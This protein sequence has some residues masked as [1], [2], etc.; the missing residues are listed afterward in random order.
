MTPISTN[1][2]RRPSY[3]SQGTTGSTGS[4]KSIPQKVM[5]L[6]VSDDTSAD[7]DSPSTG[8]KKHH[9]IKLP[10]PSKSM[11]FFNKKHDDDERTPSPSMAGEG[12]QLRAARSFSKPDQGNFHKAA[13][14]AQFDDSSSVHSGKG[15]HGITRAHSHN[16]LGSEDEEDTLAALAHKAK[17]S[18]KNIIGKLI[19]E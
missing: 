16:H 5:D 8:S 15:K 13:T 12:H 9:K 2:D 4:K 10:R 11:F 1:V 7:S 19:R 17:K 3:A 18:S 14:S 6:F